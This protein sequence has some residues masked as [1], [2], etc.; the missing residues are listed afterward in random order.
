MLAC[1]MKRDNVIECVVLFIYFTLFH[2]ILL[3]S[4]HLTKRHCSEMLTGILF[5]L[6]L[7]MS[8]RNQNIFIKMLIRI[9]EKMPLNL[10]GGSFVEVCRLTHAQENINEN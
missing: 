6:K 9:P 3:L 2:I 10:E 5:K 4:K 1:I 7:L 8:G